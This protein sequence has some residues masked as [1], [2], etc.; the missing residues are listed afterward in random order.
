MGDSCFVLT[1][2]DSANGG[3]LRWEFDTFADAH[4]FALESARPCTVME[5]EREWSTGRAYQ[6]ERLRVTVGN[7]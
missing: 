2:A 4:R 6:R 7:A 3:V 1:F 5:Y